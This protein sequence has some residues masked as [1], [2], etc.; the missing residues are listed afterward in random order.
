MHYTKSA[1]KI[2][3]SA[4]GIAQPPVSGCRRSFFVSPI[5]ERSFRVKSTRLRPDRRQIER[6]LLNL[7][8]FGNLQPPAHGSNKVAFG[9]SSEKFGKIDFLGRG[10]QIQNSINFNFKTSDISLYTVGKPLQAVFKHLT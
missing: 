9:Q 6:H 3:K 4:Q 5:L 8:D 10:N 2:L 7:I 1:V